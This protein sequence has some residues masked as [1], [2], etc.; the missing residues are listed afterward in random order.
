MIN[1]G[2]SSGAFDTVLEDLST[3]LTKRNKLKKQIINA[4][5]Y[6]GILATFSLL[7]IILLLGFVVPSIE[8]IFEDRELNTFTQVIISVSHFCRNWWWIYLPLI[9]GTI[10][11]IVVKSRLPSGKLWMEKRLMKVPLVRTLM[12]QAAMARF[13]RTMSTLQRGGLTMIESLHIAREVM[14]NATI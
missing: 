7:V 8:G 4:M 12:T 11:Y 5:I 3:F 6:P 13:C 9:I 2:E 14:K 10:A 1:A